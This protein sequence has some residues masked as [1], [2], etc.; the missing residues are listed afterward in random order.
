LA[1]ELARAAQVTGTIVDWQERVLFP[2]VVLHVRAIDHRRLLERFRAQ[3]PEGLLAF[4]V[5][6]TIR[7]ATSE[8]LSALNDPALCVTYRIFAQ[9]FTSNESLLFQ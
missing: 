5:P 4:V 9:R 1:T 8:E 3:L 2:L 7:H 6:W